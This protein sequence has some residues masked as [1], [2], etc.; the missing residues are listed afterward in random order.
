MR[1]DLFKRRIDDPLHPPLVD[2]DQVRKCQPEEHRESDYHADPLA[3]ST[4]VNEIRQPE[5]A[6]VVYEPRN[7]NAD[8]DACRNSEQC[9][10]NEGYYIFGRCA[11]NKKT[12]YIGHSKIYQSQAEHSRNYQIDD[13]EHDLP[14]VFLYL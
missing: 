7:D 11:C 13:S 9:I 4:A 8:E 1:G 6:V 14:P 5:Y 10:W 12:S 2:Y 3:E